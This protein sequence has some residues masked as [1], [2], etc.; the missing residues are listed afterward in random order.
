MEEKDCGGWNGGCGGASPIPLP[1]PPSSISER[2]GP[3]SSSFLSPPFGLLLLFQTPPLRCASHSPLA[4]ASA[5][6]SSILLPTSMQSSYIRLQSGL[7]SEAVGEDLEEGE[8]GLSPTSLPRHQSMQR[9]RHHPS[10]PLLRTT[11][12]SSPKG[13]AKDGQ[14]ERREFSLLPWR[15]TPKP[16]LSHRPNQ[17]VV[18]SRSILPLPPF[19]LSLHTSSTLFLFLPHLTRRP[20][21][22]A[23]LF[24]ETHA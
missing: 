18:P 21:L 6:S 16:A 20:S 14:R 22:F 3:L 9:R 11:S 8:G 5:S 17:L 1:P 23:A 13:K 4:A 7:A 24:L 10:L 19:P 2:G 15:K 12:S